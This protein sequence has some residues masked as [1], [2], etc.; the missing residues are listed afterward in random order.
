MVSATRVPGYMS[1]K[2]AAQE[3]GIR[4]RSVRNLIERGRLGSTRLGRLHF[5][6]TRAVEDWRRLRRLRARRASMRLR[7]LRTLRHSA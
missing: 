1:V 3:L 4:E 6:S 5:I 7:A 2:A